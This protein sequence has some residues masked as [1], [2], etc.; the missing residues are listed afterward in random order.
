[1]RGRC[2]HQRRYSDVTAESVP[3]PRGAFSLFAYSRSAGRE[4][5][6]ELFRGDACD[7]APGD[8][9]PSRLW[10]AHREIGD[11]KRLFIDSG[12]FDVTVS[13]ANFGYGAIG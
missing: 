11:P 1:M 10:P 6:G 13:Q 4:L 5:R 12:A 2:K 3:E 9:I 7:R 8:L